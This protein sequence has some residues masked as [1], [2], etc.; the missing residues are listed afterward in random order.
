MKIIEKLK[1]DKKFLLIVIGLVLATFLVPY[2]TIPVLILW[3]FYKK[4]KFSRKFKTIATGVVGGLIIVLMTLGFIAYAKDIEPHLTVS[5][6]ASTTSIKAQQITIK[7]TYDP[8]DRKV[9]ISGKEI[10]ASNG[11][12]ETVYQLKEG[13]NKIDVTTGNWKRARVYLT[14]TRE[15]TEAEKTARITQAP[16]S[17]PTATLQ[18]TKDSVAPKQVTPTLKPTTSPKTPEQAIEDKI[19]ASVAKRTNTNK[20]KIIEIRINKAF[21]ND[22]EYLVFVNMNADD[23]L[24][25][26]WIKKGIKGDMADIYIALYKQ[27]IGVREATVFAYFPMIDKYG[28]TSDMMIMKTSL[29][30][31]EAQKINWNQD[32]SIISH[33]ILPDI[34]T[35]KDLTK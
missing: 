8:V 19:R 33:Q 16:S 27:P 28:N 1:T 22:K 30:A 32:E 2:L 29:A 6:P 21:D 4:S 9:W 26:D 25:D 11:S 31:T 20:D 14:V 34:W 23:N 13:E 18:P 3:W 15:L 35:E 10:A 24:S 17:L 12:F 5:E 7:G